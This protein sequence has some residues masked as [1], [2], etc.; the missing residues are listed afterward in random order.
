MRACTH[1]RTRKHTQTHTDT[2]IYS[3]NRKADREIIYKMSRLEII[4]EN[5]RLKE[6]CGAFERYEFL[7]YARI[8]T[9]MSHRVISR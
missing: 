4:E 7:W 9:S 5:V 8:S 6:M 2:H 1:A 3:I